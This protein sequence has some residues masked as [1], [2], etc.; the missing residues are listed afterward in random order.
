[1]EV[2]VKIT[3]FVSLSPFYRYYTQTASKYFAPYAGHPLSDKYY[4]S[5]YSYSALR[6]NYLGM[7]F[8]YAPPGGIGKTNLSSMEVR[9]GH[10]TQTTEL[11][12]NV[13]SLALQFK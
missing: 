2:P 7:G 8:H 6:S 12:S 11:N 3:P 5:N 13:L 1:L 10:Y 9:F 4:T